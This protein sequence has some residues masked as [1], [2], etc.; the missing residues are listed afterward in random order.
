MYLDINNTTCRPLSLNPLSSSTKS[1]AYFFL[2]T[3]NFQKNGMKKNP[4]F[5]SFFLLFDVT[6]RDAPLSTYLFLG[7][8]ALFAALT[9]DFPP[10]TRPF[11]G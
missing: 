5:F 10:L 4:S 11:P 2:K 8:P 1:T 7:P 6:G 3:Q 9:P